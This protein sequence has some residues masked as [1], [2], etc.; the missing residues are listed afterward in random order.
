MDDDYS[1]TPGGSKGISKVGAWSTRKYGIHD[2]IY[3]GP[4]SS[5]S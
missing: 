5:S 4:R 1:A 2:I 3:R